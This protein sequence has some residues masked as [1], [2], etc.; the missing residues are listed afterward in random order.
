MGGGKTKDA[1]L[2]DPDDNIA[3]LFSWPDETESPP[4]VRIFPPKSSS[5]LSS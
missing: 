1:L 5:F 4:P 2:A 3:C